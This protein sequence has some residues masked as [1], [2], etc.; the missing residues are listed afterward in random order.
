MTIKDAI[1][2]ELDYNFG[3]SR[4]ITLDFFG[5]KAEID[6]LI[7]GEEDGQFEEAQYKAYQSLLTSWSDIQPD[8]LHS[9]ASYYVQKRR[10]MV[11][12]LLVNEDYPEVEEAAQLLEMVRLDGIVVPYA[13]ISAERHIG[14]TF[15]CTWDIE[16]GVGL[17]LLNEKVTEVGY[18]EVAI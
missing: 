5:I 17:R 10:D 1:F 13:D 8:I 3:W 12:N 6:L 4:V 2:G 15:T 16:N 18:Q 7:D 9:I 11:F 14:I